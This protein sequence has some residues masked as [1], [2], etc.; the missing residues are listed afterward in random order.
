[1]IIQPPRDSTFT[2]CF[3]ARRPMVDTDRRERCPPSKGSKKVFA[4]DATAHCS[5][6]NFVGAASSSQSAMSRPGPSEKLN[7]L[8]NIRKCGCVAG[9]SGSNSA[10]KHAKK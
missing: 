3:F 4:S 1:M 7:S 8:I 10:R 2:F 5:L 9:S 6:L